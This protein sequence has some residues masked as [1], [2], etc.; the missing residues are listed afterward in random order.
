MYLS[1]A[2]LDDLLRKVF[3][4]LIDCKNVINPSRS[5]ELGPATE[6]TGALLQLTNPR[7]RLSRT[8]KKGTVFSGLGE[9]LWY[10]SK[11]NDLDFISYY[12][13]QYKNESDDG[14]TVY[15]GYGPRLFHLRRG[16][17]F[18][19]QLQNVCTLLAAKPQ[20]RRAVVQLFDAADIAEDHKE[21]PCTCTLQFFIRAGRLE[22]IVSMRSNDAYLGLPHD[23]FAFTMLQEFFARRL[24]VKLGSYKHFVGSLHLYRKHRKGAQQFMDEG[25]Q[26]RV[27]MPAMPPGDPSDAMA[28]LLKAESAIRCGNDVDLKGLGLDAYWLDLIRLLQIYRCHKLKQR[29]RLTALK[30]AMA[31]TTYDT[32]IDRKTRRKP[33]SCQSA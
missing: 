24:G 6:L 1:D 31:V 5:N 9:L 14:K 19:D 33:S 23:V 32:Y 4:R 2:T 15:G 27:A 10:F 18:I 11:S 25:F 22:L 3:K 8:E 20:S 17:K 29:G 21:I 7:A 26:Q 28:I 13:R 12:I 16:K 30:R